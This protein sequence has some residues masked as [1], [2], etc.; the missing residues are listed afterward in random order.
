M[1]GKEKKKRAPLV[2]IRWLPPQ[3]AHKREPLLTAA[4]GPARLR[5]VFEMRGAL[6][7]TTPARVV[8]G[9]SG[10]LSALLGPELDGVT[11]S[12]VSERAQRLARRA[13]DAPERAGQPLCLGP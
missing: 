7:G 4:A 11:L 13:L 2:E 6:F 3:S 12:G 5:T 8:P 1:E 9:L 10:L